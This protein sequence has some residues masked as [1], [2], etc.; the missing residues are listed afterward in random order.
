MSNICEDD[1]S[2]LDH[3][4]VSAGTGTTA[5]GIA[6]GLVQRCPQR[7]IHLHIV[8][9]LK[10]VSAN[11]CTGHILNLSDGRKA[12]GSLLSRIDSPFDSV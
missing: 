12:K 11:A 1:L 5:A 7:E 8:S 2:K 6:Y 10:G 3:V 9:A 4:W